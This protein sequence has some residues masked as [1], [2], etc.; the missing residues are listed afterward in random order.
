MT[1]FE[2]ISVAFS[3]VLSLGAAS[4]LRALRPVFASDRRYWVH[5]TWVVA[6][7]FSHA[8][9]WWSLWSFNVVESWTLVAFL[10]VLLQPGLLYLLASLLVGDAPSS[11]ASWHEHFFRI[12]R[13]FFSARAIYITAIMAASWQILE[14]PLLH[15]A[16]A[17]GVSHIAISV[18]GILTSSERT[19][20]FL[21]ILNLLLI[22]A[23]AFVVYLGPERWGAV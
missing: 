2:Y 16:R 13:W 20:A 8:V 11:T 22:L 23:T 21:V 18:V 12:R 4:L 17:F 14:I 15:P 3:I 6:I 9:A 1:L 5:A 19:H 10:L 7:L